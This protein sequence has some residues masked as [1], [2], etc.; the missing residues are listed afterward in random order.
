MVLVHGEVGI[1]HNHSADMA[2]LLPTVTDDRPDP[3]AM[4]PYQPGRAG[5]GLF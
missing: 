5:S 1:E 3:A 2:G 4:T